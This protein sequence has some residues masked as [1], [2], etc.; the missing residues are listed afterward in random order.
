[1]EQ[2]AQVLGFGSVRQSLDTGWQQHCMLLGHRRGGGDW[3]MQEELVDWWTTQDLCDGLRVLLTIQ[4]T[5]NNHCCSSG[6]PCLLTAAVVCWM[7][8]MQTASIL[9][10]LAYHSPAKMWVAMEL[11][12][13]FAQ[14]GL[15]W[16]QIPPPAAPAA[17]NAPTTSTRA[18]PK[19]AR[20][21][22]SLTARPHSR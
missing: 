19:A 21:S 13:Q 2:I 3:A 18:T 20:R 5:S 11:M 17:A 14:I 7:L 1:M 4:L 6:P 16:P 15:V 9:W 22:V 10:T 12:W 8:P